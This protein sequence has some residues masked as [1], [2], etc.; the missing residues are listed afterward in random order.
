MVQGGPIQAESNAQMEQ[1]VYIYLKEKKIE[2]PTKSIIIR[3]VRSLH[4]KFESEF[5]AG[6]AGNI[7]N[8]GKQSIRKITR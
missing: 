8:K 2:A 3:T 1:A 6:C 5:F 4:I 7:S